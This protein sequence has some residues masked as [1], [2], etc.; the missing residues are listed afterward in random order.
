MTAPR[1]STLTIDSFEAGRID[2]A[3]FDHEAHVYLAWLYVREYPLAEAIERFSAALRRLTAALGVP[4]KYHA[5]ITWFFLVLINERDAA[6]PGTDWE[7]FRTANKDLLSR[8][9]DIVA[10]YY[11]AQRL[12]SRR[13]RET[14]VLPDRTGASP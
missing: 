9:E 13:A 3:A 11:T 10:R 4:G 8:D 7:S 14:F 1:L 6:A 2:A 5:S 12:A